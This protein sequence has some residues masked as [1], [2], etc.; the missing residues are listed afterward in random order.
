MR[1]TSSRRRFLFALV[2]AASTITGASVRVSPAQAAP[3]LE[4]QSL[5]EANE[6]GYSLYRIPGIVVTAKGTVLAYC[7]A[8]KGSRSDW[9]TIDI[10]LRRSTDGGKTFSPPQTIADV[11]GPK[12]KNPVALAQNLAQ[13]DEVTYNNPVA[14]AERDGTVHMLFCLEYMRCFALRSTDD[15]VTWTKPEEITSAFEP[16]RKEYDWKVLA[17]GPAHGIQLKSG[18][19][20]I[21]VWLSL[22]TGGHA[23]RPSVTATIYS[24]DHG[25]TWHPGAIAV[26]NTDEFALPN[27]TVIVELAD[28]RV[29]LNVRSEAKRHRRI[30]LTSADGATKWTE[31]KFDEA[32]LEPI[33]MAS[34]VRVSHEGPNDRNR[35]LFANPHNLERADGKV[36]EGKSRDR[37]NIS[38]KLS[39][40]E[41]TSWA[42]DKVLDPGMS[43]YSDL[44]V[45]P[46]GTILCLYESALPS[47][48]DPKKPKSYGALTLSRFNLEWLTD[49]K[50]VGGK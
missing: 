44:A 43:A 7:E 2:C 14:F 49:G 35:I 34:I 27:E 3:L 41:G 1:A 25:K 16:F 18:R 6:G 32:L 30:V 5:W 8:R 11:P 37:K 17:T 9:G 4:R 29:M 38:L 40:D 47:V 50:D 48:A 45:L 24:D 19:L 15:G 36:A 10:Q 23:H 31:P 21:P 39:Y 12:Q 33:C 42:V 22:G 28:G 26:P 20:V 46:D 13:P